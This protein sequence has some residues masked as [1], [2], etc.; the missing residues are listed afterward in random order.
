MKVKGR[1]MPKQKRKLPRQM[2]PKTYSLK[3]AVNSERQTGLF[4]GFKRVLSVKLAVVS[5]TS[6]KSDM[7]RTVQ[8]N[9]IR[10]IKPLIMMG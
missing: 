1:N 6:I 10:G 7:Q 3:G 2:S 8:P 5:I 9:P 4:T